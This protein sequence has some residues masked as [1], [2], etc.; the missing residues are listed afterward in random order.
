MV[1]DRD[2]FKDTVPYQSFA[3][4]NPP[5]TASPIGVGGWRDGSAFDFEKSCSILRSE[6][7]LGLAK[8]VLP[9]RSE[10]GLK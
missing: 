5:R 7:K 4:T 8:L 6:A 1:E 3:R 9:K 2:H 10:A